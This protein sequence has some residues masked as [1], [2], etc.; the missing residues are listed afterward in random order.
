[1][2]IQTKHLLLRPFKETDLNAIIR[3]G[4]DTE[5]THQLNMS[6]FQSKTEAQSFLQMLISDPDAWA[7]VPQKTNAVGGLIMLAPQLGANQV[8][9]DAYEISFAI[10]SDQQRRGLISEGLPAIIKT[11][12]QN[13]GVARFNAACFLDNYPSQKVLDKVGFT[14]DYQTQLP[15]YLGGKLVQYY[16][17]LIV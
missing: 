9:V 13:Q 14:P 2:I 12:H 16:R 1:M 17:Y 11:Y 6:V 7:V 10:L 5:I 15:A 8:T 3:L 4:Q